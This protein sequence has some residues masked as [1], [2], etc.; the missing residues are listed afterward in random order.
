MF[1]A[2]TRLRD[3]AQKYH[4]EN[5]LDVPQIVFVGETST[6][7]SM[8]IQYFLRFP[9][10]FSQADVATRCPVTYRLRYNPNL[11]DGEIHFIQ[12]AGL[13][14]PELAEHLK[15]KMDEFKE[16]YSQTGGFRLEPYVIEIESKEYTD[17]EV[18]DVPGLVGGAINTQHRE[19]VERITEHYVRNPKFMIV[20]VKTAEQLK[21]NA[22]GIRT[23]QELC[24]RDPAPCGS[25]LPPRY[26][27]LDHTITIH[28]KFDGFMQQH[29]NGTLANKEI[30]NRL[31]AY[32]QTYFVNM[33]FGGYTFDSHLYEEN[34]DYIAKL[35]KL[36]KHEVDTW[37][38]NLNNL[39]RQSN[40]KYLLFNQAYRPLIG[41][42]VVRKQIQEL[43]LRAF[44]AALPRPQKVLD[45]LI[46]TATKTYNAA[47]INLEQQNPKLVRQNYAKYIKEF[48]S[49]ISSYAAYQA[50]IVPLFPHKRYARTYKQME[51][52]YNVWPRKQP[53]T[54]RAYLTAD[55]LEQKSPT[56]RLPTL[57]EG[58]IGNVHFQRLR[59]IFEYMILSYVPEE[60]PRGCI[61][62]FETLLYGGVSDHQHTEKAVREMLYIWIRETFVSGICWLTQ[63]HSFLADYFAKDVREKLLKQEHFIYLNSHIKFLG[64]VDLEYHKTT[65]NLI[66]QAVLSTKSCR[67]AK[68]VYVVHDICDG[69]RKLAA[70]IPAKLDHGSF[71]QKITS[72]TIGGSKNSD[73]S[74][75]TVFDIFKNIPAPNILSTIYGAKKFLESYR[76]QRTA[77]HHQNARDAL[78]EIY[79]AIRGLLMRDINMNFYAYVA[80]EIV[81]YESTIIDGPLEHRICAMSDKEI[82][83]MANIKIDDIHRQLQE[84]AKKLRDLY[85]AKNSVDFVAYKISD[86]RSESF[87]R[88]MAERRIRYET[89]EKIRTR[90]QRTIER[91]LEKSKRQ[92]QQRQPVSGIA[93]STQVLNFDGHQSDKETTSSSDSEFDSDEGRLSKGLYKDERELM[94]FNNKISVDTYLLEL[95]Q[96]HDKEDL[97]CGFLKWDNIFYVEKDVDAD[98]NKPLCEAGENPDSSQQ[99]FYPQNRITT[100]EEPHNDINAHRQQPPSIPDLPQEGEE[101]SCENSTEYEQNISTITK[102]Q[103]N[104][105]D[106]DEQETVQ[107]ATAPPTVQTEHTYLQPT[108]ALVYQPSQIR[109]GVT[110]KRHRF[111]NNSSNKSFVLPVADSAA[112]RPPTVPVRI[113]SAATNTNDQRLSTITTLGIRSAEPTTEKAAGDEAYHRK[114][115]VNTSV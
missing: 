113:P 59:E 18:L 112:A 87:Q 38:N 25:K 47:L 19:A 89:Q 101:Y 31:N 4:L 78:V 39:A 35:P 20:Q 27:Y 36:E 53:L 82:T 85:E 98:E 102:D 65:R 41:I 60:L 109:T 76:D 5:E 103:E 100:I 91:Q 26:D 23:I 66:R 6:G 88:N 114:A 50:E 45:G 111:F 115:A 52:A 28:T 93:T 49:T 110:V 46:Q 105:S 16:M 69:L 1:D 2:Y 99:T 86:N 104:Q 56:E 94:S 90:R 37:I 62:S 55:E 107:S 43:W 64:A 51:Q 81:G 68:S 73:N 15:M 29:T 79:T 21:L 10:S 42:D 95:Y 83:E 11:A 74:G 3:T 32:K 9:C 106:L 40:S 13:E 17:F 48:R 8:L 30:Q 84:T 54:W 97:E 44:R 77:E 14:A 24:T 108:S 71:E 34:I 61:A 96:T 92:Q 33:I 70:S 57:N 67:Y 58:Y 22:H 75:I 63:M 72:I 7:K 80:K 12:P